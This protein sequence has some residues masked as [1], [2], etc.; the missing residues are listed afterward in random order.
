MLREVAKTS[1]ENNYKELNTFYGVLD[2]AL[3]EKNCWEQILFWD[4]NCKKKTTNDV[5]SM[6]RVKSI[7]NTSNFFKAIKQ[8]SKVKLSDTASSFLKQL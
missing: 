2:L 4:G 3:N 6:K 8:N 5:C 7:S 1:I